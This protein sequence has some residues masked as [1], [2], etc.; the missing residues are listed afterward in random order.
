MNGE[1]KMAWKNESRRHALAS[2]GIKTG[3][4]G[5]PVITRK[6]KENLY[7]KLNAKN[8]KDLDDFPIF[9][10]F[11][12]EQ[13]EEGLKKLKTTKDDIVSIGASGFV[14]KEDS[15]KFGEMLKR[16]NEEHKKMM[17]NKDYVYQMFR[18]ELSNHEYC[19]TYDD[20]DT[21]ISL[22]LTKE[23]VE[24]NP[25]LTQQLQKAK[26]DYLEQAGDC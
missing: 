17:E 5:K 16:H 25:L 13:F 2:K 7:L 15:K 20:Y 26:K 11:S 4:K 24:K 3:T 21:L 18:Y 8:R 22:N 12:N 14:K 23:E 6:K 10:A 19:I 1:L 9:F